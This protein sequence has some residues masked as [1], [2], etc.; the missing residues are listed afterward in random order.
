MNKKI[1][2]PCLLLLCLINSI[3]AQQLYKIWVAFK[4]KSG[5][6]Y[7]LSNPSA[8]LTPKSIQRRSNYGIT[9]DST[10]LPVNPSYLTQLQ[11][12]PTVTLRYASKWLNGAVIATYNS[13]V[14]ATI[15]S[16]SFVKNS[17]G[18]YPKIISENK[19]YTPQEKLSASSKTEMVQA[20]T[21]YSYGGS[22]WQN[23]Q[24]NLPCLHNQGYRG[25][26]MTIGIMDAG[27][28]NANI[29]HAFDSLFARGAILGTYDFVLGGTNLWNQDSHGAFVLSCLAGIQPGMLMGSAPMANYWLFRSEDV[30]SETISEEYNW[31]RA[32]EFA[33]SV[34]VDITTTS[35]GYTTFDNNNNNHS[36]ND[37]NGRTAPISIAA[38]LAARKGILVFNAA[39]NGNGSSWPWISVPADADS[40]CTVGAVDSAG[41]V[42]SFSSIG[43]TKDGRVKPDLVARGVATWL[44]YGN[45]TV[46]GGNGTSFATP[47]LA[48]AAACFWQAHRLRNNINILDT[49]KSIAS[50]RISPNNSI[51]WGLPN[52]CFMQPENPPTGIP[53]N[54]LLNEANV[55]ITPNPFSNNLYINLF[56]TTFYSKET[57]SFYNMLGQAINP[58]TVGFTQNFL[59][60]D[61][62]LIESGV[63]F[64]KINTQHGVFL[65]KIVKQ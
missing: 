15:A 29:N 26:G 19:N 32:A 54:T 59:S 25:Q 20:I 49:L 60:F 64:A 65:K 7:S 40:I 18:I 57:I 30:N 62:S 61:F 16:L 23:Q 48:G 2:L 6:P 63:Y 45:N 10:D 36:Y 14:A 43:P 56:N 51:G 22:Y 8:Y 28:A 11:A 33:D 42:A 38:N 39:G 52:V 9:M 41:N 55:V 13:S 12:V 53:I 58:I 27:F 21:S 3:N 50:N 44:S 31:V 47:V 34:G 1:I 35:L 5:T 17:N 4:S 46:G 37:L 24:L